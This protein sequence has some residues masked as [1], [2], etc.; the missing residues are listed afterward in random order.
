MTE[1]PTRRDFLKQTALAATALAGSSLHGVGAGGPPGQTSTALPWYRG[2][3]RWGQTNI[4]EMDPEA[5]RHRLV[6]QL[7][8]PDPNSRRHHQRRRH[9]RLLSEPG[10]AASPGATPQWARPVRRVVPRRPRG[11]TGRSRA[12]GLQSRPGNA[13]PGSPRLVCRGRGRAILHLVN[14]TNAGTWRQPVHEL[15]PV[16]PLRVRLKLPEGVRG[17]SV[18]LLVSGQKSSA[19][20]A[21]GWS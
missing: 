11:R 19:A 16:G 1:L 15:I 5:L 17:K 7:L 4:T 10:A 2:T 18:R 12:N 3:L 13:L 8:A 6:A 14:L 9:C 20:V 21:K